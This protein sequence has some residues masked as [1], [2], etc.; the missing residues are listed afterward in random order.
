[1][2][3]LC[4]PNDQDHELEIAVNQAIAA[5]DGD[6]RA[7]VRALSHNWICQSEAARIVTPRQRRSARPG[8]ASHGRVF[9]EPDSAAP[10]EGCT[11]PFQM[12]ADLVERIIG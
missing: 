3:S 10:E 4:Q 5:C 6:T 11:M 9:S 7:A 12:E 2:S 1:M 8:K